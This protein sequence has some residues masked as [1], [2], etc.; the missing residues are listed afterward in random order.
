MNGNLT[1]KKSFSSDIYSFENQNLKK[2]SNY[3]LI[4]KEKKG[5]IY[6][7]HLTIE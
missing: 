3:I 2:N 1:L 7:K 4:L 5:N 6:Q